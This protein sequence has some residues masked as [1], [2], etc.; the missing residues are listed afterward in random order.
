MAA[1]SI[2]STTLH[3]TMTDERPYLPI[4]CSIHDRLEEAATLRR[5]LRVVYRSPD[6]ERAEAVTRIVDIIT[7]DG[8]ELVC[9]ADAGEVRLDDLIALDDINTETGQ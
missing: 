3:V 4:D 8:V 1:V 5:T 6:G 7:R 2:S 9:L